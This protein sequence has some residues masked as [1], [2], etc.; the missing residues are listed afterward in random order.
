MPAEVTM[1]QLSDTMTE[2]TVVKWHKKEGD[3]IKAGEEIADVETDK[4]TM[5]MESFESG[6]LAVIKVKEGEKIPVGG[7]LAVIATGSENVDEIKKKFA[8]AGGAKPTVAGVDPAQAKPPAA[9]ES[10]APAPSSVPKTT[11]SPG[12]YEFDI[13]VIGG[14][15]AG[16]A[17]AIRAGQLKK[18]VLCIEKENLG[19]TCLNW[20]CIPTKALLEDGSFIRKMKTEAAAH[21][22]SFDNFKLDFSKIIGRSR[23]I[24]DK[25]SKG[26]GSLFHKYSVK[27]EMGTAKLLGPHKV[28][29]TSSAGTKEI[30][31]DHIIIAV[32]A[33]STPLP[34]APFDGKRII[35]S[36]EAMTLAVQPK[37]LAIIGAGAIGCEFADFYS[38]IGTE[39]V[40]V[41]MLDHLLPNEDD[42]V[43]RVLERIFEKR[44]ID[45]RVKTKTEKVEVT[46]NGVKLTLSGAKPGTVEAD[47]VLIAVGVTGNAEEAV[48]PKSGLELFRGRVKCTPDYRTNLENVWGVGDCIS[49]HWPEGESMGGYRHPDLAHVAHHEAV[50]LVEHIAGLSNHKIDYKQIPGCT[51]THPQVAS[52]GYTEKRARETGR[53]IKIGK[54]PFSASGRALAAGEPDGFVKLIFDAKY[55]ELLGVHMIGEN[56]TD[57]LAELVMARRLEATEEEILDA[58]HPHPTYSEAI[59]EAAGVAA[60]KAIHL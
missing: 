19:G 60:G 5:P 26:I 46:P 13:L 56:V 23:G 43:A 32:G 47:A 39:I 35:T 29:L 6:T 59:M 31:A 2:G 8:S 27:S 18:K 48:D 3:K 25:L 53:E 33:R 51:Y 15:P 7:V 37:K 57:M 34:G 44:K 14:G 41:E 30:T 36:R 52:M 22:V 12:K 54:F 24:A 45:V 50:H 9:P 21:G 28:R 1:P 55:G 40:I 49:L 20:G 38:A 4:A 58:I 42:D 17:A 16:Y 11:S 10:A